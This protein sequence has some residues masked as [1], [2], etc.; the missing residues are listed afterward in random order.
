[1]AVSPLLAP[2]RAGGPRRT[3]TCPHLDKCYPSN[4]ATWRLITRIMDEI[5]E[6]LQPR[7]FHIGHMTRMR[8]FLAGRGVRPMMWADML[9]TKQQELAAASPDPLASERLPPP[10]LDRAPGVLCTNWCSL[11]D[12]TSAALR[13]QIRWAGEFSWTADR[14]AW[15]TPPM[16][17][18]LQRMESPNPTKESPFRTLPLLSTFSLLLPSIP[19][20]AD[21][22]TIQFAV[23]AGQEHATQRP[24]CHTQLR[25]S[26]PVYWKTTTPA[27]G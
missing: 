19:R 22:Q 12:A 27:G 15:L 6:L 20:R 18:L 11:D 25:L 17:R 7:V 8:D 1:V 14:A 3:P 5:I 24:R 13:E 2:I 26:P 10:D 21:C 4:P 23:S 16:A 9:L